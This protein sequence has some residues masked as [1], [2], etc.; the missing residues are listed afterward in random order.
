MSKVIKTLN[1]D[2][3]SMYG[4]FIRGIGE[5]KGIFIKEEDSKLLIKSNDGINEFHRSD[6]YFYT[7]VI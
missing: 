6:L 2:K 3:N 7:R 1:L 4:F 5:I